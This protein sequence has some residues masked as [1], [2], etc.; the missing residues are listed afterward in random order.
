MAQTIKLRRSAVAGNRP[1]TG[2]LD[3]G[4]LAINTVDG[5]IYFERSASAVETVQEI[6]TTNT[7]NSGS[8]NT[9]GNVIITGSILTSGSTNLIGDETITGSL[10]VNNTISGSIL[11]IGNVTDYST[12]VDSRIVVNSGR[13]TNIELTSASVNI[14]IAALNSSSASQ[15]ISIDALNVTSASLNV[16]T[17]S[18]STRL[19]NIETTSASVNNSVT[20]L[21]TSSA[22][23]QISIDALN[24][25]S[26]S[27]LGRLTNLETTSASV[28]TSVTNLNIVS[29]SV[30][31]SLG[32]IQNYT[33]SLRTAFTA[34]GVNVTFN[35]DTTIKGN[36]FV[37]GTQTVVDSTTINLAD[38]ILVLNA[39][40]TSDGGLIV[41]D[42]TG[43]STTSGS[44]LWDV[45]YDYW[46]AGKVGSE[47]P[48]L[49][50]GGG[51]I[52]SGSSQLTSSYDNRYVI[53]GS[54]TQ[55]TWNNIASKPDGIVS[56][57]SQLTASYDTRYTISGSVQPL[58]SNLI[59]SSAQITA[60][61]FVSSSVVI[62]TG[63]I[64]GSSQLTGS[65]DTRYTLS[66]S[67]V[68]G[69]TPTGTISGSSQLEGTT[70]QNLSGS[71]TGSFKGDGSNLTGVIAAGNGV[72]IASGSSILG[73]AEQLN[74]TGS[75]VSVTLNSGTASISI[76]GGSGGSNTNSQNAIL[77][78]TSPA[79]TW[80]F[81]HNLSTLYP[82][83][84]IY[85]NEDNVIIPEKIHAET[86]ASAFIYFSSARSGTAVASKG[87]DITSASFAAT[88]S[89]ANFA[90]SASYSL[91]A[92][93]AISASLA[94]TASYVVTA[95]TASYVLNAV[96]A[97]YVLYSNVENKPTLVSGSSQ[98]DIT[99]TTGYSTFS[100]SIATSISAS[101]VNITSLSS[102][103][104]TSDNTQNGRLSNLE[105]KSASVDISVSNINSF[106]SSTSPR[107]TNLES[108]SA[109]VDI[110]ISNI[111]SY[112]SSLKT[113]ISLNGQDVT[114]NGNLNVAGT[115]TTLNSTTLNIGDNI[116]ELNYGGT[117]VRSGIYTKDATGGSLVSG[118][119]LW[120]ATNDYWVAGI[121]GSESKI[122]RAD[123][124]GVISGSAQ[125]IGILTSLNSFTASNDITS[126]NSAT[127]SYETK[128]RGIISGSAQ[129]PSGIVSSSAQTILNLPT[130][131]IS[132]SSQLTS[133]YDT[134][135]VVSGSIT[136]TTWDNI[137]SK[138]SGIVSGS[139]QLT[140]SYDTRYVL[141]GSI[142]QTTWD[143]IASKPAGIVSGSSQVVGILSSLN[144][145][146]S[147]YATTGSNNF[148]GTQTF[149][150]SVS[151]SGSLI[152]DN[153]NIDTSRYLHSQSA[154]S[155]TWTVNHSLEYDYPSVTIYDNTNKVIIPDEITRISNNQLTITFASAESGN[156][157]V[158]VG[159][160][161][162][163]AGDRYLYTQ[164]TP[165][166]TWTIT[167]AL[168]YKYVNVDVYDNNDQLM[169]PQTVTATNNNT[170]TL[171]FATPTS[172]NATISKGGAK[173]L[174]GLNDL[175]N[176][177][178]QFTG[179][180]VVTG[181]VDAQNFNTTSDISLKTNLELIENSLD[182][183]EKLNG[184]TFDWVENYNA[185]G[186]KQIG[187]IAQEVYAVQ[188][189]LVTKKEILIGNTY[190]EVMLLDYSKVTSLL[191]GAVKELSEKVKQLENKIG[192]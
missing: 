127:S 162:N 34:S 155:T 64:S 55:T 79:V 153:A 115:T 184:Y 7:Q 140:S 180:L 58:P 136:Q 133:S 190:E 146:T 65:Y 8:L 86:T 91:T 57:S 116:I 71:F 117:A 94:Q 119:I 186:V 112:T 19:S 107:L 76:T 22:S 167:H 25:V 132:G 109:S 47:S 157:H 43:A 6:F 111:N 126:L 145:F 98:V 33:S 40:G 181:E 3:L 104:Y 63:T 161:S 15:Q 77:N 81:S 185:S 92:S 99:S 32:D 105:T 163:L 82:V 137:A 177:S 27:N 175:G 5:K 24:V 80:S 152:L 103:V 95:Q 42:T 73:T 41:R 31:S 88:A 97:S 50:A 20:A 160:I 174:N 135:Y 113:A 61:G 191:I 108:K 156:A 30:L 1:T 35:G 165:A 124:D 51:D 72:V 176:G 54:I 149:T 62:P 26:S 144:S 192:Q 90:T 169:L 189:E 74:F 44:L 131:T 68:S 29:A 147:S 48:I 16:F 101:N 9:I 179:S 121:S 106:T 49:L 84:T 14:S 93:S 183:V 38:N 60:F 28:N 2:Q 13:L 151:I 89:L 148:I 159:G 129:L 56:G 138:P 171:L 170:L 188:P 100:S 11:G 36:L 52:I 154:A 125:V 21:N 120:D 141:S 45:T 173:I 39:A 128:G 102:S 158:S 178:Y 118:S 142:T 172:G 10:Y 114:V 23:Q 168:N 187:M 139:T 164:S 66:G 134:R 122:L 87:G 83:F 182:K 130:G 53:S 67:V 17:A 75:G 166:S 143:N 69:T 70:I 4:E 110:S 96:S 59:S 37:Q 150:G 12:S 78:Q 85:D 18:T 123:S 46:K